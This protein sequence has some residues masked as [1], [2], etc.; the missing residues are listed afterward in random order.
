VASGDA[1]PVGEG[2]EEGFFRSGLAVGDGVAEL[3]VDVGESLRVGG[4]G[5]VV[6]ESVQ[7]RAT[8]A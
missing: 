5:S 3:V 7:L 4:L 2:V 6:E 1:D 8:V